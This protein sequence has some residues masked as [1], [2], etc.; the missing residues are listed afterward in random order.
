MHRVKRS[1]S[2]RSPLSE[3]DPSRPIND[4]L[5]QRARLFLL[6][7]IPKRWTHSPTPRVLLLPP[8]LVLK[9]GRHVSLSE[10][11]TLEFVSK[12]SRIPVPRVITAYESESGYRY[13]L[14]SRIRGVPLSSVLSEFSEEKQRNILRQLRNYI[15]ELRALRPPEPGYVG[16]VDLTPLHDER[17]HDGPLGPFNSVQEFHKALRRGIEEKSGHV[18][19]DNMIE[20]E[21]TRDYSCRMT[22]GDLSFRNIIVQGEKLMGI[23]DW[24]T[25]GWYPDY[26]EYA[27]TFYSFFDSVDLRPRIDEFLDAYPEK[28]ETEQTRRRLFNM[29]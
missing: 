12:N 7:K 28:R 23:V 18:E 25:A 15:N 9:F 1:R 8:N 19:L 14:M 6:R 26:W 16:A 2:K 5:F 4:T 13:I 24:E 22:H 27:S 17:V 29:T 10:A 11:H 3:R 20:T 21:K